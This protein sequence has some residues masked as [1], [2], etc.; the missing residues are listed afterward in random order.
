MERDTR[1]V[2]AYNL[3]LKADERD[4]YEFFSRAGKVVDVKVITDRNTKK[5]KGFAYIEYAKQEETLNALALTGQTL[6]GQAVMVKSSEAEKNLAWE[7]QQAAQNQA[8]AA[9]LLN[10]GSCRL[11]VTNLHSQLAETD[12]KPL[13]EPF[14]TVDQIQLVKDAVGRSLGQA[15]VQF[16]SG[17]D[18]QRAM[19]HWN[20]RSVAGMV[21]AVAIAAVPGV[22]NPYGPL[23][24]ELDEDEENGGG[25]KLTSN[26]RAALMSRLASSA[27]LQ[28][29]AGAAGGAGFPGLASAGMLG[30]AGPVI[31]D[32]ALLLEQGL[33]GPA[34]PIPTQC[35]LLKNM[36]NPQEETEPNW[37]DDIKNDVAEECGKY[38]PVSH[39]YVDK[40][41]KGFVY[42]KFASADASQQAHQALHGRWFA[43]RQI[44][45]EYQF[46][47]PYCSYFKC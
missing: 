12:L 22:E 38:G 6:L 18:A 15:Y 37:A 3:N 45:A 4:I 41:S 43:G 24:G 14:G 34:S 11:H 2:F 23:A 25:F 39:I 46:V 27:G 13:F 8:A 33:F 44:V 5:S 40:D 42:L 36:F 9:A 47:Q 1:T 16:K 17:Q 28:V 7:A 19:Q 10:A 30:Q 26:A 20:G 35:L 32:S 31:K 29:N 21:L